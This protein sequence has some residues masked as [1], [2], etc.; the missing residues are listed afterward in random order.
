M[1]KKL[2]ENNGFLWIMAF[3][4]IVWLYSEW[5]KGKLG[6]LDFKTKESMPISDK[7]NVIAKQFERK[8]SP[9]CCGLQYKPPF[10]E[11]QEGVF[12]T[13]PYSTSHGCPCLTPEETEFINSRGGNSKN[14]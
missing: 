3:C 6:I 2:I 4:V 13:S 5:K 14:S 9:M 12:G 11:Q 7:E 10:M 8:F 1:F